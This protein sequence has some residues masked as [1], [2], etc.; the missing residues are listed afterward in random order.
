MMKATQRHRS[1]PRSVTCSMAQPEAT[2]KIIE[3]VTEV[4]RGLLPGSQDPLDDG[5]PGG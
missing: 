2:G 4:A 5:M 1:V 3:I